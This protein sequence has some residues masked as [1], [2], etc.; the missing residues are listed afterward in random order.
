M[1]KVRLWRNPSAPS[2]R[3]YCCFRPTKG[4]RTPNRLW[5]TVWISTSRDSNQFPVPGC[6]E[7][8]GEGGFPV[9]P[10]LLLFL[11]GQL[12]PHTS[13]KILKTISLHSAVTPS[14]MQ[15]YSTPFKD[16][17]FSI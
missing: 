2:R 13:G 16:Q 9:R 12:V 8:G 3:F 6:A 11:C 17:D 4:G 14:Y 10:P 15:L 7:C 1:S 5:A